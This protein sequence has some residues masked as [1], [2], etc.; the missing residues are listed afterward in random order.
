[1]EWYEKRANDFAKK[2]GVKLTILDREYKKHFA[3]DT[4]CRYVFKCRLSRNGKQYTFNF[5]Q[6]I[7]KASIEPTM[8]DVLSCLEIHQ[9]PSF[10]DFCDEFGY[11]YEKKYERI[12]KACNREAAAMARLFPEDEVIG[13]LCDIR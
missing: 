13:E 4:Q 2:Y 10:I 6:S 1:M 11:D 9:Y 7:F 8:Y 5:G 12:W 3:D